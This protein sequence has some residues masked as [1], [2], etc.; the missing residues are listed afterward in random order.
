MI[1]PYNQTITPKNRYELN[2]HLGMV[3]WFTGYSGSGKSTLANMLES[4]LHEKKY[5]TFLLDG[6]NIRN[7]INSD[8]DLSKSG[9]IENIRR[10]GHIAKLMQ[11]AGLITICSFVSPIEQDRINVRTLTNFF[12]IHVDCDIKT[13]IERDT[14]GLYKKALNNEINISGLND[15]Y[16]KPIQPESYVN[17]T[18]MTINQCL[19][20]IIDDLSWKINVK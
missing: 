9:R 11:D 7:G 20:K 3:I 4:Y 5:H 13:V 8:L 16:Q 14:K 10:V 15:V 1:Y 12:E 19:D 6:D 2:G 18:N 17:T